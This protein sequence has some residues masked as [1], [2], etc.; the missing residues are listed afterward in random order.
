A[1]ITAADVDNGSSD[2]C[3]FDLSIDM[4]DFDCTNVGANTVTLMGVDPAG[5]S[6]STTVT[7][8]IVDNANPVAMTQD[9]SVE[10]DASGNAVITP[11]MIN[12]GSTDNCSIATYA[13]DVTTFNCTNVG[14]NTVT[15][16]VTDASGNTDTETATVTVVDNMAPM[17]ALQAQTVSLD[18]TGN[19]TV[20][21]AD[22]DNGTADN[23]GIASMTIDM[24][25]FDCSHVG[26][27][28]ITFTAT[29]DNG[30]VSTGTTTLTIVD[31]MDPV[32]MGQDITVALNTDGN[33]IIT[34]ADV[35]NGSSD[36]CSF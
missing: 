8:T 28:T 15:L 27:N 24:M 35:D 29:D 22:F 12:D 14:A 2:N 19:V 26:N 4:T 6:A 21:A 3:S 23:C 36:N 20:A 10:L 13:L 1:I 7:V 31:D 16:T 11:S 5:N 34:A 30:N 18:A 17:V 9:I 32:V 25:A 33:A